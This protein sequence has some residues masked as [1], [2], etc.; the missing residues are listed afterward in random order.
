MYL[1]YIYIYIYIYM[2]ISYISI[3]YLAR[4]RS[5]FILTSHLA[6]NL[7]YSNFYKGSGV[8][9]ALTLSQRML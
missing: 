3:T 6:I 9:G 1:I 7:G 4:S 5:N 8:V 2:Y